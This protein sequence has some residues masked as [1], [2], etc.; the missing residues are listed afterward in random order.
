MGETLIITG[1]GVAE[2]KIVAHSTPEF[3]PVTHVDVVTYCKGQKS[4]TSSLLTLEQGQQATIPLVSIKGY[5][6]LQAQTVGMSGERFC[7]FTNP[8][9]FRLS[10][11][12]SKTLKIDFAG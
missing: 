1:D 6:R 12:S 8:I 2:M 10:E 7:C 11:G 9:W 3:G 4:K 5:C